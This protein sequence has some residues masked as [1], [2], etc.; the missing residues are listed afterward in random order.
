MQERQVKTDRLMAFSDGVIAVIITV[1]VL[2]LKAPEGPRLTDL[3][4]LWPTAISYAVSYL[5]VAII[6][7]NHHHLM[8]FVRYT[9]PRL[10]WL[11]F[12]HLFAVSLLP[13]TTAWVARSHLAPI[14]VAVYGATFV[15]VDIAYLVFEREVLAQADASAM[16]DRA[17][18]LARRR[19][20]AAF[21]IFGTATCVALF[22]PFLGFGL[23]CCALGLHLKPEANAHSSQLL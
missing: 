18:K 9:T 5:F 8:H 10:I 3:Y 21:A 23:I 7:I 12:A 6:W 17:R 15:L 2:E 11:N 20:I 4:P 14:P 22:V 1:M 19:S 13:F 16:P